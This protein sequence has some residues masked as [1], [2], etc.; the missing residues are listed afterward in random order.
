M[1]DLIWFTDKYTRSP[2]EHRYGNRYGGHADSKWRECM[3]F[4]SCL[5]EARLRH[6]TGT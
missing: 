1:V 4:W 5:K 2:S 3:D 6:E